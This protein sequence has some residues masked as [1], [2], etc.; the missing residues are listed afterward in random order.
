MA[1]RG[2]WWCGCELP[3]VGGPGTCLIFYRAVPCHTSFGFLYLFFC[4]GPT[5][6]ISKLNTW[7]CRPLRKHDTKGAVVQALVQFSAVPSCHISFDF[8]YFFWANRKNFQVKHLAVP[9]PQETWH[10]GGRGPGTCSISCRAIM[11][12]FIRLLV[13]LLGQQKKFSI[14]NTKC[15]WR[16]KIAPISGMYGSLGKH[17]QRSPSRGVGHRAT[18]APWCLG[19]AGALG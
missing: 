3:T 10:N 17:P 11:P 13:F 16:K 4:F 1:Q 14:K 7:P 8:L 19:C 18:P 12:Y 9:P 6:K 2:P 15:K 5:E